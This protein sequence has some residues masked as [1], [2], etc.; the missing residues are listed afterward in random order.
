MLTQ[1]SC[2][3][4]TDYE[5]DSEKLTIVILIKIMISNFHFWWADLLKAIELRKGRFGFG[6]KS[7]DAKLRVC[8]TLKDGSLQHDQHYEHSCGRAERFTASP[9][10]STGVAFI[11]TQ[12]LLLINF[13]LPWWWF[14]IGGLIRWPIKN[15]YL[16]PFLL[17][18]KGFFSSFFFFFLFSYLI[19][20]WTFS[21]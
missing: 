13:L 9:W 10:H 7:C 4:F 1:I 8:Y 14:I 21:I 6:F 2:I 11:V 16:P 15:Y 5:H 12:H 20:Q 3:H 17:S 19:L 18:S